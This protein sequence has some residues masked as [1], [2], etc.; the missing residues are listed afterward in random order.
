MF[1]VPFLLEVGVKQIVIVVAALLL[2]AALVSCGSSGCSD[3]CGKAKSCGVLPGPLGTDP[4][5][6][7]SLC[8]ASAVRQQEAVR[9]CVDAAQCSELQGGRCASW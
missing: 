4:Q 8:A 3:I 9:A 6:C 7:A 1:A 2:S 5:N